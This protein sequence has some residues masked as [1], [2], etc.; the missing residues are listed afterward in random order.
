[1]GTQAAVRKAEQSY[2]A[3][4]DKPRLLI[5]TDCSDRLRS[6]KASIHTD[7]VELEITGTASSEELSRACHSEHDLV[8]IDVGAARLPEVLR[9]L[10]SSERYS[11]ISLLVEASRVL[12]EPGL[13]GLLP[14]YRAMPCSRSDM[15]KLARRLT[16][17]EV[18]H[19][20]R[21]MLL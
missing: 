19:R 14:K 16:A 12:N 1:M 21:R 2:P 7:G 20:T 10:R 18:R 13:A 17:G 5:V 6:L 4:S 15:L 8:V 11:R 3:L 9:A